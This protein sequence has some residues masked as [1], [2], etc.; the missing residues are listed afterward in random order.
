MEPPWAGGTK[1]C[2]QY[3]GH[4]AKMV[5]TPIYGK[6]PFKN[7]L[8]NQRANGPGAWYAALGTWAQ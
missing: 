7:I 3:L 1:V 8:R 4:M 6:N 2:S 5:I